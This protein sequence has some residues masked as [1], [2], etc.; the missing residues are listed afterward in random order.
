MTFSSIKYD[1]VL[2]KNVSTIIQIIWIQIINNFF[3]TNKYMVIFNTILYI[4]ILTYYV[5]DFMLFLW[6]RWNKILYLIYK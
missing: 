5:A 1:S 6:E 3:F 2:P 4:T